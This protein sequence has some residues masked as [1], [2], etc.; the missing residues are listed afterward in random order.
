MTTQEPDNQGRPRLLVRRERGAE[1]PLGD[2]SLIGRESVVEAEQ[3][4]HRLAD[5]T[6]KEILSGETHHAAP[7][8]LQ[9]ED[10]VV[11]GMDYARSTRTARSPR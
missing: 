7:F 1:Q 10:T 11:N 5:L 4:G 3:T 8:R 2:E 6:Y 9:I